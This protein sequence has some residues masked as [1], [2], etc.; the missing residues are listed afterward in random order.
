[1]N[2][3]IG[4][5]DSIGPVCSSP[6]SDC[7]QPHWNTA[8][9]TPY[10]AAIDSRFMIAALSGT[11]TERNTTIS[12]RNDSRMTT[13]IMIGIRLPTAVAKSANTA[14]NPPT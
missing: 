6:N 10:A 11:T 12:S 4:I 9:S 2:I 8:T 14:V 5:H 13:A 1:M 7:P 3:I